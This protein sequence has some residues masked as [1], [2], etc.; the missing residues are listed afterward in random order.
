MGGGDPDTCAEGDV[1]GI[2]EY[3]VEDNN[4]NIAERH[5]S[6]T[7]AGPSVKVSGN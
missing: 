2:E 6:V 4:W 7:A 1:E 3:N 5:S